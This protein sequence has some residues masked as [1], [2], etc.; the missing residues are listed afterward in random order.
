MSIEHLIQGYESRLKLYSLDGT[1]IACLRE[2]W[3]L[4]EPSLDGAIETVLDLTAQ[5]FHT[6]KVV[7][8]HRPRIKALEIARFRALLGGRLDEVYL[9]SCVRTAAEEGLLELDARMRSSAGNIVFRAAMDRLSEHRLFAN[10]RTLF[11]FKVVS[12]V[13][14]M[15]VANAMSLHRYKNEDARAARHRAMTEATD[16]FQI[17]SRKVI[18]A[19]QQA[20]S[21]LTVNCATMKSATD[22][23]M[24]RMAAMSRTSI[25][26]ADRV[27]ETEHA[28][29]QLATS[30]Q[31]IGDR[32]GRGLH[33]ANTAVSDAQRA[34]QVIG[35]LHE[36]AERI[37]SVV[38]LISTI[39][40][41]TNLLALNATIEAARAGESGKGFAVVA[42][43]VKSLANQTSLA[44]S[45]I[46]QQIHA[47]QDATKH[48]VA[49]IAA[50]KQHIE[51]LT[52][53]ATQ[54][55]DAVE[56]QSQ[57]TSQIAES[58]RLGAAN[59]AQA[60]REVKSVEAG[61]RA[62]I[63]AL[64]EVAG[65]TERLSTHAGDLQSEVVTFFDRVR[66]A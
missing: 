19:I 15:D 63:Q 52:E 61:A 14:G 22:D 36:A 59:T 50:V 29:A 44:T 25:E 16:E 45:Q 33:L 65:W 51:H 48:S 8:Q 39:A 5:L 12:Q 38:G 10:K 13:I 2:I 6:A 30:I 31:Q 35:S 17:A 3:P 37:G 34:S 11:R 4:I 57:M 56:Q 32:A 9:E 27:D 1:A 55:S 23:T 62:S 28:A 26:A 42:A 53:V 66:S 41:Q 64:D 54:I 24:L 60:S 47:I 58:V 7:E 40:A 21:S 43:E 46:T 20:S 18:E 49:E